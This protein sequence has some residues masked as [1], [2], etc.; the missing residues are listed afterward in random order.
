MSNNSFMTEKK[1]ILTVNLLWNFKISKADEAILCEHIQIQTD[2]F[3][4][5]L[6]IKKKQFLHPLY[7][8][9]SSKNRKRIKI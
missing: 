3:E 9:I 1:M 2:P 5:K 4:N 7:V 6:K 8:L